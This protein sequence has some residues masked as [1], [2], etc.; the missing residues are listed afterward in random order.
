MAVRD[1]PTH[2][3]TAIKEYSIPYPQIINA[4]N[5]ASEAYHFNAIPYTLLFDP[6]GNIIARGLRGEELEQ[7]LQK[8]FSDK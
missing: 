3:V 7:Q 2:T 5:T 8:I 6:E 1:K 4:Q